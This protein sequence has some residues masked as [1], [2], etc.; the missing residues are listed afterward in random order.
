MTS[1]FAEAAQAYFD[2]NKE[3]YPK[4]RALVLPLL[5][6][7]QEME[8]HISREAM[9]VIGKMLEMT[10]TDIVGV[11]S[12]YTLLDREPRG[13]HLIQV[14]D[15]ITCG[16]LASFKVAP[17][18]CEKLGVRLGE[19]TA[20]QKFTVRGVECLADCGRAPCMMVDEEQVGSLTNAKIDEVL[21]RYAK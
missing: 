7:A 8:G 9:V 15:N 12:F 11:A 17:Y 6:L 16:V 5:N 18:V 4:K 3:V 10:V 14:C 20:D 2:K 1:P 21:D 13:K 19:T